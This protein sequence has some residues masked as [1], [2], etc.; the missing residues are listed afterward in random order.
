M[1]NRNGESRHLCLIPNSRGK[2]S[3]LSLLSMML[4][5]DLS[6][7]TLCC[8]VE[9]FSFLS[10]IDVDFCQMLFLHLLR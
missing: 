2:S 10:W 7:M 4:A 6:C 5:V 1:L 8:G 3:T 9:R